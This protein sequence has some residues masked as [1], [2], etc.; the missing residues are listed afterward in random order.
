MTPCQELRP[1]LERRLCRSLEGVI[2][3]DHCCEA[4]PKAGVGRM[5][6]A[7]VTAAS[8]RNAPGPSR[9]LLLLD[10]PPEGGYYV[11]YERLI[12]QSD[13]R[14][15]LEDRLCGSLAFAECIEQD[16]QELVHARHRR[17]FR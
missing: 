6:N 11:R 10:G 1:S 2:H 3:A 4:A 17:M 15:G 16:R 5:R 14:P 7:E 8:T 12:A 9:A 13:P